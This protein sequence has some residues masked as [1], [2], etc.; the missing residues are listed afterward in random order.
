MN[1]YD[2]RADVDLLAGE[3]QRYLELRP[4]YLENIEKLRESGCGEFADK[5]VERVKKLDKKYN[6]E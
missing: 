3:K 4:Q 1:E 6:V 5:E 2:P